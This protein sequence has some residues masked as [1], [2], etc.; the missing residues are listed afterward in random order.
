MRIVRRSEFRRMPWRN[1]K[2]MTEEICAFP[3]GADIG[4]F[5]WRLSIAH[6]ETD[7]PFST[8]DGVDRSIALLHGKGL[9]LDLPGGAS[10][11]LHSGTEPYGFPGEWE[12]SS[13][14][15]EGPTVDLNIMTR[16]GVVAHEMQ[17]VLLAG[18]EVF[19]PGAEGWL[20]IC[21]AADLQIEAETHILGQ[22]DSLYL[23]ASDEITVSNHAV[24]AIW[25]SLARLN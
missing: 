22:W 12:I 21:Q 11:A 8:F 14:N 20:V 19:A 2:G 6:V 9:I 3:T 5:E 13:R 15:I 24:E 25:I 4:S 1:N 18:N 7:G 17:R 16:R 23:E 10:V